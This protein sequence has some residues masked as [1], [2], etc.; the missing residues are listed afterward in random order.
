MEKYY[1]ESM[2]IGISCMKSVNG[3]LTDFVAFCVEIAFYS[4]LMKER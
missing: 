4:G 3:R 2:S 1:L